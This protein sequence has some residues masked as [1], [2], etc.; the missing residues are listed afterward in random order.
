MIDLSASPKQVLVY[1][2]FW[3]GVLLTVLA[4]ASLIMYF[5][6]LPKAGVVI[7]I[8]VGWLSSAFS[9]YVASYLEASK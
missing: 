1:F 2:Y 5:S 3:S 7:I 8:L 6:V 9:M 4:G